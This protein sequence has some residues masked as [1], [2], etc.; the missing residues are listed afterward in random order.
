MELLHLWN[1]RLLSHHIYWLDFEND[2]NESN[3]LIHSSLRVHILGT[4]CRSSTQ[5]YIVKVKQWLVKDA[6]FVHFDKLPN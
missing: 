4:V 1:V 2:H 6:F 5:T 3:H